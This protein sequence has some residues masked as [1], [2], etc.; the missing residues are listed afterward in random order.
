MASFP[1][2]NQFNVKARLPLGLI[3]CGRWGQHILRDLIRLG[4]EVTVADPSDQARRLAL[5]NGAFKV[6]ERS[7][8][9]P[10]VM[11]I[12]VA[13][14]THTHA[15]V[16]TELLDRKI[17]L[18]VEKPL[19]TDPEQAEA[20]AK[21]APNHLFVMDKWRYHP[22]IEMLAQIARS[23]EL[24]P[25][26]G[27]RTA[28]LGWKNPHSDVDGIW[29][30][31]PHDL[32]IG[33]EILGALPPPRLAIAE[34]LGETPTGLLGILGESPWF[35]LEVSTQSRSFQR[36]VRLYC[37]NGMALLEDPYSPHIQLVRSPDRCATHDSDPE[38]RPISTDP[39]LLREL[40]AFLKHLRGGP[41]PR[42]R[43]RE[44]AA[45]VQTLALLRKLAGL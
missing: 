45:I 42:S 18:F 39:P 11:G 1:S 7:S 2:H 43:A 37:Q 30:L 5:E 17:P 38:L 6:V 24:G 12:V 44:G 26:V 29:I 16:I 10:K 35:I 36:E 20:L 8:M 23:R 32:S 19:T 40:Q 9:L 21:G 34:R 3:G 14:S 4:C 22:G 15:M 31:A 41:P 13:T 25:V 28:R 33:M 27:L